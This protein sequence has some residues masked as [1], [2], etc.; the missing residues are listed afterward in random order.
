[1]DRVQ[2]WHSKTKI[3]NQRTIQN[4]GRRTQSGSSKKLCGVGDSTILKLIEENILSAN[5]VVTFPPFEIKQSDL[6]DPRN[7][8]QRLSSI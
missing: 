7:R 3:K 6:D 4:K 1:M 5:Q 2:R 8:P